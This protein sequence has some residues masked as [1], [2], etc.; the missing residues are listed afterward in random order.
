MFV[1]HMKT[2]S[3]RF[4]I[5]PVW[6]EFWEALFSWRISV[7]SRPN[8]KYS[9]IVKNAYDFNISR[10]WFAEHGREMYKDL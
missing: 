3:R 5:P 2:R 1:V 9:Y 8:R 10:L 7:D 6:R 4:Q